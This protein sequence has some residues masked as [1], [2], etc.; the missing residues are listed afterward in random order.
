MTLLK[1]EKEREGLTIQ[2]W[3]VVFLKYLNKHG[4]RTFKL[5]ALL[6]EPKLNGLSLQD[7][8]ASTGYLNG[9]KD[10]NDFSFKAECGD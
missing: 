5:V 9:F 3:T 2:T 6:C 10:G 7:F 4:I 8:K 1:I